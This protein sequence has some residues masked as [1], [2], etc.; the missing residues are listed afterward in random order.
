[1]GKKKKKE[2]RIITLLFPRRRFASSPCAPYGLSLWCDPPLS[3]ISLYSTWQQQAA[4]AVVAAA[5]VD[6]L[7]LRGRMRRDRRLL[8]GETL[9][10]SHSRNDASKQQLFCVQ[11]P[12]P[13]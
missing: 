12:N 9:S 11:T 7:F 8:V 6:V 5:A 4:A 10:L 13:L 2:K 1:M 3:T